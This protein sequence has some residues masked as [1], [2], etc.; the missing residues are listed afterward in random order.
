MPIEAFVA[1]A[2]LLAIIFSAQIREAYAKVSA[3][4]QDDALKTAKTYVVKILT[5]FWF[6]LVV[7]IFWLF[8]WSGLTT[9]VFQP[10]AIPTAVGEA[11]EGNPDQP[12]HMKPNGREN[13]FNDFN[14][15]N[16]WIDFRQP[17]GRELIYRGDG[18]EGVRS[19]ETNLTSVWGDEKGQRVNDSGP[20]YRHNGGTLATIDGT[21]VP[22]PADAIVCTAGPRGTALVLATGPVYRAFEQFRQTQAVA[23]NVCPTSLKAGQMCF[24]TLA[25][26]WTTISNERGGSCLR[27][28]G[29]DPN[30]T[31]FK[32]EY[33]VGKAGYPSDNQWLSPAEWMNL[34]K[35]VNEKPVKAMR[36]T[37]NTGQPEVVIYEYRPDPNGC[38]Y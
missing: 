29:V 31:A 10:R 24:M 35:P 33:N 3:S 14:V 23:G 18:A 11:W 27:Y 30:G 15:P 13:S 8:G 25:G 20:V 37:S 32:V 9:V 26:H 12:E 19:C 7:V 36:F 16:W 2:A 28:Q 22:L 34:L 1:I 6:W 17:P 21:P 38:F 4:S 5:S